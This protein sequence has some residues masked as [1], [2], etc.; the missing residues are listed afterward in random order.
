MWF[1]TTI[2]NLSG[3]A[4]RLARRL[5]NS[6][7]RSRSSPALQHDYISVLLLHY[8]V[9]SFG[10]ANPP[11]GGEVVERVCLTRAGGR[12]V[13][14]DRLLGEAWEVRTQVGGTVE[15]GAGIEGA[16]QEAGTQRSPW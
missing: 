11:G 14:F 16:G 7:R 12:H 15:G 10:F 1:S 8:I 2:L 3:A 5:F 9:A 6:P 4:I 13:R